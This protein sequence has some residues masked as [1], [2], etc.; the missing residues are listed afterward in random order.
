MFAR[1]KAILFVHLAARW[2][3]EE[4]PGMFNA[5]RFLR[6]LKKGKREKECG[7]KRGTTREIS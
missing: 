7:P 1:A 5:E 2:T 6:R 4:D 3:P